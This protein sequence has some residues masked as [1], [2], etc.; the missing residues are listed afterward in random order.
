MRLTDAQRSLRELGM[1]IRS[2]NS[3]D[4]RRSL[5]ELGMTLVVGEIE[6]PF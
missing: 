2:F 3:A 1:T 6:N 5:R 4:A